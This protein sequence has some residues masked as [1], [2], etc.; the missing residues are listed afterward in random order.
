MHMSKTRN[1]DIFNSGDVEKDIKEA[2]L[3]YKADCGED[4]YNLFGTSAGKFVYWLMNRS[5]ERSAHKVK[6]ASELIRELQDMVSRHGD[7]PVVRYGN[8]PEH[9]YSTQYDMANVDFV[10]NSAYMEDDT[11]KRDCL[12]IS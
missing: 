9:G 11:N 10:R 4:V 3:A 8:N 6:L 1:C 2:L 12:L 7:L 5:S